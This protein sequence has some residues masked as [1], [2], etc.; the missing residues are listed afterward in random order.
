MSKLPSRTPV[1]LFYQPELIRGASVLDAM[2]SNHALRVLRLQPGDL[3]D[4]TDGQGGFYHCTIT[5]SKKGQCH[6]RVNDMVSVARQPYNIGVAMAPTKNH[7]RIE[8]LVEKATE[9]G[10]SEIS[11]F[12]CEHS[13]RKKINHD[14]LQKVAVSA[15][16]QSLK[17][18]LP[19][20]RPLETFSSILKAKADQKFIAHLDD[21]PTPH[22]IDRAKLGTN[23]LVLI[24]P[25][26]DF[27][28]GE[29]MAADNAGFQKVIL[30]PH[31]LRTETA[32]LVAAQTLSLVNR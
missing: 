24:G 28:S 27:S 31:R 2:E 21:S 18:W 6:F 1:S 10:V 13:E 11:F 17:A 16:K 25:E 32:A 5:E 29:L 14:R 9:V 3:F 22:L 30:G 12:V 26:G 15:M 20:I 8:W 23:Y 19:E 4:V 7:D